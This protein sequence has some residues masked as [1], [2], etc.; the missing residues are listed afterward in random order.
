MNRGCRHQADNLTGE[1]TRPMG[2]LT[3]NHVLSLRVYLDR[4]LDRFRFL[5]FVL[6]RFRVKTNIGDQIMPVADA[7]ISP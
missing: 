4:V 5:G 7:H 6:C 2:A 1:Y 3:A